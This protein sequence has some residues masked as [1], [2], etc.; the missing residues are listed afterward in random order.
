MCGRALRV[1]YGRSLSMR[2][3]P[4][5]G[6]HRVYGAGSRGSSSANRGLVC[7]LAGSPCT[8]RGGVDRGTHRTALQ[9]VEEQLSS[10][11]SAFPTL[12]VAPKVGWTCSDMPSA[13]VFDDCHTRAMLGPSHRERHMLRRFSHWSLCSLFLS[14]ITTQ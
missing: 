10:Y 11:A 5:Y 14:A 9:V 13:I 7:S 2:A 1:V 12:F 4:V 8:A 3:E 6:A